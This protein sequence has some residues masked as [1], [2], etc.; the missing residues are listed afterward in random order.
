MFACQGMEVVGV[1]STHNVRTT[2][3]KYSKNGYICRRQNASEGPDLC[4]RL[5][6][7]VMVK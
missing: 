3:V 5:A 6:Q 4:F 2:S 7:F 1:C